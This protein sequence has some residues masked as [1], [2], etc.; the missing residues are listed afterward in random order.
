MDIVNKRAVKGG[1]GNAAS[2]IVDIV[3]NAGSWQ[4]GAGASCEQIDAESM[5]ENKAFGTPDSNREH[6]RGNPSGMEK[7]GNP[8]NFSSN[9]GFMS[10]DGMLGASTPAGGGVIRGTSARGS[11]P[12]FSTGPARPV[13]PFSGRG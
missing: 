8:H 6:I 11:L 5:E 9:P 1:N 10:T 2:E 7:L 12:R 3:G 4:Y 13:S